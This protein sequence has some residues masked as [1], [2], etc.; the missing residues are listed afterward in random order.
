M[1]GRPARRG[2]VAQMARLADVKRREYARH[3]PVFQRPAA[4]AIEIHRRW[5]AKLVE[6]SAVG[7]FVHEREEGALDGFGV[8]T[9]VP[10]PPV[11]DPGGASS[12]IDDFVVS[13]ERWLTAGATLL[14]L[15][16]EWAR[17]HGAV[18]VVV[19]CGP[20]D[21]AKRELLRGAGLFVA[22]EWF[23]TPLA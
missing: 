14:R 17:A 12:L 20:H 9:V 6:A 10:T 21:A 15:A 8:V 4:D 23:T 18:Q 1:A 11:Y 16:T 22:S 3:A 7:A 5:L 2:D 13:P 19:V